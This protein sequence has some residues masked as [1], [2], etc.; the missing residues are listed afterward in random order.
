LAVAV[1][2]ALCAFGLRE[3]APRVLARRAT[4]EKLE[5]GA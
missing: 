3:T 5:A 1:A 4:G 2:G